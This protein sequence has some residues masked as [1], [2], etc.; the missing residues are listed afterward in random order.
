M[1]RSTIKLLT[2]I[3]VF[4]AIGGTAMAEIVG[5]VTRL[6]GAATVAAGGVERSLAAGDAVALGELVMTG[7][8]AR[9]EITFQDAS[10]I[11]LGGHTKLRI[12]RMVFDPDQAGAVDVEQ[13]IRILAG[14]FRMITGAI[15][16]NNPD[17]VRIHTP[18][19]TIGIRGTDF[20]GG[21][22]THDMPE[23]Q[24]R[25]GILLNGGAV[26]VS[27]DHGV[28]L[29]SEAGEGTFVPIDGTAAP[30]PAKFWG[31]GASFEIESLLAFE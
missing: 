18:V 13:S 19:A 15:G 27:N 10:V 22:M 31:R 5:S 26:A 7:E 30:G 20:M 4:C 23:G 8:A 25:Y 9:L 11:T 28:V 24:Y 14:A 12:D 17:G 3:A 16:K 2:M 1:V 29:L 6:Q 21:P